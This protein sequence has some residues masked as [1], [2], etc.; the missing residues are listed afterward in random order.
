MIHEIGGVVTDFGIVPVQS[1]AGSADEE[2]DELDDLLW[3]EFNGGRDGYKIYRIDLDTGKFEPWHGIANALPL[4]GR[5]FACLDE[6]R[7]LYMAPPDGGLSGGAIDC[8]YLN[9]DSV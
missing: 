9:S 2:D 6:G 3:I 7:V 4:S 1:P 5:P 8:F